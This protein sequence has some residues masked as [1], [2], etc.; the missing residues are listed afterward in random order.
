MNT[1][2]CT[3]QGFVKSFHFGKNA[4]PVAEYTTN[5]REAKRY[6]SK[7]ALRIV[8]DQNANIIGFLYNPWKEEPI[9]D[10]FEVVLE[11]SYEL[12]NDEYPVYK[13][14]K[15]VMKKETDVNFLL[16]KKLAITDLLSFNDATEKAKQLNI[17]ILEKLKNKINL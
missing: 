16:H 1:F 8:N 10:M 6:T 7:D 9:K 3:A 11:Q 17:A 13:V 5:I 15:A 2:I 12:E 14:Q 4:L